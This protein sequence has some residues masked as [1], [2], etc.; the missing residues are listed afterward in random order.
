MN[1]G[2]Y[3]TMKATR[4]KMRF[5]NLKILGAVALILIFSSISSGEVFMDYE[6][7]DGIVWQVGGFEVYDVYVRGEDVGDAR[8]DYGQLTMLDAPAYRL[9]YTESWLSGESQHDMSLDVKMTADGLRA[10]LSDKVKTIDSREW[11]F[12]GNYSGDNMSIEA[13]YP[14]D[15]QSYEYTLSRVL[16]FSDADAL[17]F[18]LRNI[19]FEDN[20]FV[21][22]RVMDL[23]THTTYT[24]IAKIV[25]TEIVETAQTQYDCWVVNVSTVSGGFTA[26]YSRTDKH[27]LVK[28]R[29]PDRDIVLDHHS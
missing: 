24:P 22:L 21:T 19:P 9:E 20:N 28:V 6:F 12:E 25:G 16:A 13:Y 3:G 14:G 11:R 26:W 1:S 5:V 10:L 8:V 15:P 17:P 23:E 4:E 29:Y 27:Y 18:I 2:A 7:A